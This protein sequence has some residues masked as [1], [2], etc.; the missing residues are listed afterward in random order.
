[1]LAVQEE[2]LVEDQVSVEALPEVIDK[3]EAERETVGRGAPDML[4]VA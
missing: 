3:G 2:A 4:N 1:M